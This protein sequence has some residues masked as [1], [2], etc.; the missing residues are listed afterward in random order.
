MGSLN[1]FDGNA[2]TFDFNLLFEQSFLSLLPSIIVLTLALPR[3]AALRGQRRR[4]QARA[5]QIFKLVCFHSSYCS[6]YFG[7]DL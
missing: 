5:L 7:T 3:L 6:F 4:I 2:V 1:P